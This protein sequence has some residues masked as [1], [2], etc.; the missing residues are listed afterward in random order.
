MP[1]DLEHFRKLERMYMTAPINSFF[2]PHLE[3]GSGQAQVR[4][5]VREDFFH[6][7][8]AM[9]GAVYFKA[10][11]DATYFA[12]QSM[13]EDRFILTAHFEID[14]LQPVVGGVVCA[15]AQV[16]EVTER[17]LIAAGELLDEQGECVA[18]G[19]GVFVVGRRL[20]SPELGYE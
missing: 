15:H 9:H 3:V 12:A 8:G 18:R 7:A 11:D 1:Q 14:L 10:L 19:Q 6:S 16:T 13:V 17:K 2:Q 20:L 5:T 4:L